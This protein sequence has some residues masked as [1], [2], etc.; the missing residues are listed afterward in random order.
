LSSGA[1]EAERYRIAAA[2]S[3]PDYTIADY[4]LPAM[5]GGQL[6]TARE[7]VIRAINAVTTLGAGKTTAALNFLAQGDQAY[8]AQNYASDYGFF[9]QAYQ[10]LAPAP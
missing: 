9:A 5:A 8:N 2:L 1:S 10:A 6:E 7:V 3:N 4:L